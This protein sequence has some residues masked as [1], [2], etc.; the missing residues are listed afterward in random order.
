M[1][2]EYLKPIMEKKNLNKEG[3]PIGAVSDWKVCKMQPCRFSSK[4]AV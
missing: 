2:A 3:S 1:K 4:E